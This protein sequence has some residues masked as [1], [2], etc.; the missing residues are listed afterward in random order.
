MYRLKTNLA[1]RELLTVQKYT[2]KCSPF[3]FVRLKWVG[4]L[5]HCNTRIETSHHKIILGNPLSNSRF[6]EYLLYSVSEKS[7]ICNVFSY[8]KNVVPPSWNTD[9]L[10]QI[11]VKY[12]FDYC[13]LIT[14]P[15]S[16]RQYWIHKTI[17]YQSKQLFSLYYVPITLDCFLVHSLTIHHILQP[18][19]NKN[20]AE[21]VCH[22]SSFHLEQYN[23]MIKIVYY[24]NH[25]TGWP[26][27]FEMKIQEHITT[28]QVHR[29]HENILTIDFFK[30]A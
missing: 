23:K 30:K 9:Q 25:I 12:V 29:Q 16:S 24:V 27:N 3:Y 20:V 14:S 7:T 10:L 19:G 15:V 8:G 26:A 2:F 13:I 21:S 1:G 22:V 11:D 17:I 5:F 6:I 18:N 4:C 28:F